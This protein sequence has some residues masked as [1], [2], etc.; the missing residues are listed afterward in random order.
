LTGPVGIRFYAGMPLRTQDGHALGALCLIDQKPRQLD[1]IAAL[2]L[3]LLARQV[4][5]QLERTA[6]ARAGPRP[7]RPGAVPH[8]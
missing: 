2:A 6:A 8:C 5:N 1:P 4:V 3:P 7:S